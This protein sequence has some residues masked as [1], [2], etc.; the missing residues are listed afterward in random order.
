MGLKLKST[1]YRSITN[2][3]GSIELSDLY[4]DNGKF[5]CEPAL[6]FRN[7]TYDNFWDNTPHVYKFLK[8]LRARK[9]SKKVKAFK[10]YCH[11]NN[12]SYQTA[13]K[14]LRDIFISSLYL[15]FWGK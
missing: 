4:K 14:E 5:W 10:D 1:A 11:D 6:E 8:D 13:K 7:A 3:D 15:G 2:G 9:N 12:I